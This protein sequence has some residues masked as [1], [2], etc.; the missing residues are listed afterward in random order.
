MTYN[1]QERIFENVLHD[2]AVQFMD[3]IEEKHPN[4]EQMSLDEFMCEYKS[5][6]TLE[7]L[8]KGNLILEAFNLIEYA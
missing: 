2:K 5:L 1:E 3:E 4:L 6:L 8:Q 7:E